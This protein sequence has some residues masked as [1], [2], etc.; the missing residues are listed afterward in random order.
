MLLQV[1][2]TVCSHVDFIRG[3]SSASCIL[4]NA[5]RQ[6]QLESNVNALHFVRHDCRL[7]R[8]R[9]IDYFTPICIP[10]PHKYLAHFRWDF[11][12]V[13]ADDGFSSCDPRKADDCDVTELECMCCGMWSSILPSLD[14][15]SLR[16]S[17]QILVGR[18]ERNM[19]GVRVWQESSGRQM[20]AA[21]A[22]ARLPLSATRSRCRRLH[23]ANFR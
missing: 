12:R 21:W 16:I 8:H 2:A 22:C 13:L 20:R 11:V 19:F 5:R 7:L 15:M 23:E 14:C 1:S 3:G 18:S 17:Y 10:F 9:E 6:L 4:H